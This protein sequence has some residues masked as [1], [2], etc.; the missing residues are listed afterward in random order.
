MLDK[1][2]TARSLAEL[3]AAG[4]IAPEDIE[5]LAPVAARYAVAITP[6]LAQ[7]I[8]PS[9]LQDPIARQF[10]PSESELK[11]S[12]IESVDPI[13]D[14]RHS[15]VE[16]IVHRYPDR[17]LL[18]LTHLCPVYCRFCFRRE[19]V[20]PKE[21]AML[22]PQALERAL[23]YIATTPEVW[24]VIM[25]G[26]DPFTLSS[27][28]IARLTARL[29]EIDHV[30][31]LRWHTRMPI[32]DPARIDEH[33]VRALKSKRA[34]YVVIHVNHP[35]E[36]TDA[37]RDAVARMVDAGI[38]VL[39]QSVLLKGI[40]DN[41]G[42][43]ESL[44]RALVEAR[45]RPYYLHHA[46]LAPGTAHFRSSIGEGQKLVRG[47]RAQASGLCQ[48]FYVLDIPGGY[49]KAQLAESDVKIVDGAY[50]LRDAQRTWRSYPRE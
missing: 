39:S 42:T 44:M 19:T 14:D 33:L 45:I 28:R 48:P 20:G 1:G 32:A 49:A 7:L 50:Q 9:D 36:L 18:K 47:L 3:A 46:D 24:E 11:T 35:R 25:T 30:K 37:A 38:P 15:P 5:R 21:S 16:G 41:A 27:R 26:G 29:S 8:D 2:R 4:H 43:L 10:V 22:S 12:A 17:V 13:G 31:V 34:C 23:A 6:A 40:N